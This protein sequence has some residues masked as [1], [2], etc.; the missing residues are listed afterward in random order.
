ML[1]ACAP[2]LANLR[3]ERRRMD[4]ALQRCR[5]RPGARRCLCGVAG[6]PPHLGAG[7]PLRVPEHDAEPDLSARTAGADAATRIDRGRALGRGRLRRAVQRYLRDQNWLDKVYL[8]SDGDGVPRRPDRQDF[9][10]LS[11]FN[12]M[13]PLDRGFRA[14]KRPVRA[15]RAHLHRY[16]AGS[17]DAALETLPPEFTWPIGASDG[18]MVLDPG[19]CAWESF[20]GGA[21]FDLVNWGSSKSCTYRCCRAPTLPA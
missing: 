12:R 15:R 5:D 14:R 2:R 13:S 7:E 18:P 17:A 19:G 16:L 20:G 4:L 21:Y 8:L 6:E 1:V 11:R 3:A 9:Q 10:Q